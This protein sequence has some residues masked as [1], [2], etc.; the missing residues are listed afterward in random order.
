[1]LW[2]FRNQWQVKLRENLPEGLY[3]FPSG[4][5]ATKWFSLVITYDAVHARASCRWLELV[6]GLIQLLIETA[7]PALEN[8]WR[9]FYWLPMRYNQGTAFAWVSLGDRIDP[10]VAGPMS[11]K[12]E[13]VR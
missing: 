1:M 13:S 5:D 2:A 9:S 11:M 12:A 10:A 3:E 4:I 7:P 6:D 8:Q